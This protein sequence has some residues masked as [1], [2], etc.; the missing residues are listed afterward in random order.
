MSLQEYIY[1]IE[2]D[3]FQ[4]NEKAGDFAFP[5]CSCLHR[6]KMNNEY[7][8]RFCGHNEGIDEYWICRICGHPQ[9]GDLYKDGNCIAKGTNVEVRGICNKCFYL[10]KKGFEQL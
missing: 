3:Y 1:G 9:E 6:E 4:A 10:I 8:C 7:P 5:C 2:N